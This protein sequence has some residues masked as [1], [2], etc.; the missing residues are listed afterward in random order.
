MCKCSCN[1]GVSTSGKKN[2][3]GMCLRKIKRGINQNVESEN[4]GLTMML[5]N[6]L[7]VNTMR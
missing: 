5:V 3:K 2:V 6:S 7:S 1:L 4:V